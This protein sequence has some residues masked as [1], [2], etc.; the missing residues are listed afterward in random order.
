MSGTAALQMENSN[1]WKKVFLIISVAILVLLPV[2]SKNYGLSGDEWLE[3]EY[4]KD[5]Y[6][7][8]FHGDKQAL[9][10]SNKSLQ[11]QD[12]Q[13]YGGFFNYYTELAHHAFPNTS[14]VTFKNACNAFFSA[15]LMIFTGLFAY[16]MSG[17]KWSVGVLALLFIFFSPRIFGEGMNNPKDIPHACGFIMGIYG[18]ICLLQDFPKRIW[19]N[20]LLLTLG[21]AITFGSRPAGGMLLGCFFT[22]FIALYYFL[23]KD[24]K[25]RLRQDNN[26]LLKKFLVFFIGAMLLGFFIGL[27]SWPYGWVSPISHTLESISG[28]T[29]REVKIK[30]LFEGV[31]HLNSKQPWYY[32]PKWIIISNPLIVILG[33]LLFFVL[34]RKALK[35]YSLFAV[36]VVL[37]AAFFPPAYIIY[38]HSSVHDSWRHMF[39]IYPYWVTMS[40]MAFDLLKDYIRNEKLK[41]LPQA[42]AV[43]GLLPAIIW[44]M[45]TTPN[46]YVYFNELTGGVKGA[47]GQY[48]IDYYQESGRI[49]ADW[50][51]Q[52]IKPIPGKKIKV[53]YTMSGM[54]YYFE[55]DSNWLY[56]NYG[57]FYERN[58]K[59]WDYFVANPRFLPAEL[60][61]DEKWIPQNAIHVV[62]VKGVPLCVIL[63]RKSRSDMMAYEALQ[64]KDF[65]KAAEYYT[66]YV[67]SD[68]TS[69]YVYVNYGVALASIGKVDEGIA[70]VNNAI[71]IDP[72]QAQF[73]E[74][75][76][77]LYKAKGDMPHAQEAAGHA[78][79]IYSQLQEQ[80]EE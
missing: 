55:N 78:Q 42:I 3:M 34:L 5:I 21:F 16:R 23:N 61:Q 22:L 35:N 8:F 27:T 25:N 70:A 51:K 58:Q 36:I 71:K 76:S 48:D 19:I 77:N 31:Y 68:T 14:L 75:L 44:I 4:G 29:N 37:F 41:W 30:V 24:F 33:V 67:K 73:Y 56:Y 2:L 72:S 60:M 49:A 52:N 26:K 9:D 50:I 46:Q 74:L 10:Y 28:M 18:L 6:N 65:P 80:Q 59:D 43:A 20:A 12:M 38:K 15:L 53:L 69:Q 11:Y 1:I 47:Y 40:A 45:S 63:E 7:F 13:L 79:A 54:N 17:K 62:R 57:R 66:D 32:E 64:Q 39:F